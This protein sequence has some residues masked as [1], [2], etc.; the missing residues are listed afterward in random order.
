MQS[1]FYRVEVAVIK[2]GAYGCEYRRH[3]QGIDTGAI[4]GGC[5]TEQ[6]EKNLESKATGCHLPKP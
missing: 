6:T 5:D 4:E 2:E 3:Y 1:E